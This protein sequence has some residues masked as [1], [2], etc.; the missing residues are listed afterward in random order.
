MKNVDLDKECRIIKSN[1]YQPRLDFY[2]GV[3]ENSVFF[4]FPPEMYFFLSK[5]KQKSRCYYYYHEIL[6]EKEYLT[7]FRHRI[8]SSEIDLALDDCKKEIVFSGGVGRNSL[9]KYSC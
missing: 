6:L 8:N 7:D 3:Q 5:Y 2:Y 9:T 1:V 4:G